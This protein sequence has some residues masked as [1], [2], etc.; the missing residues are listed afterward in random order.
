MIRLIQK[1]L[2]GRD[3]GAPSR[4]VFVN[5]NA[6]LYQGF[7]DARA[8]LMEVIAKALEEE[9]EKQKTGMDKATVRIQADQL[10]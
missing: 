10:A 4:F 5:F 2:L 8:A 7:D 9:A 1:S 6:W 3:A